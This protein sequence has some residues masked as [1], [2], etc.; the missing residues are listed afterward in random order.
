MYKLTEEAEF[1]I[2]TLP[3]VSET[4]ICENIKTDSP[5]LNVVVFVIN[6][7]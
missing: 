2:G 6:L 3:V 4:A 1:G 7:N 5:L